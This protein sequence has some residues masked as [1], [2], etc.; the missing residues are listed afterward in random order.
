MLPVPLLSTAYDQILTKIKPGTIT[1]IGES[2]KKTESVELFKSLA[3]AAVKQYQ[4]VV[5][6]LEIASDQQTILDAVI[7]GS[8]GSPWTAKRA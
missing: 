6:G 1:V 4:C 5:I 2:H 8:K 7:L 3:S